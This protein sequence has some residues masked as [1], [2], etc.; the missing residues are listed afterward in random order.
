MKI[1]HSVVYSVNQPI[2]IFPKEEKR[3]Q[4][5]GVRSQEEE[6]R[7]KSMITLYFL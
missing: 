3:S 2:T 4:E 1:V 5:S 6:R 7:S